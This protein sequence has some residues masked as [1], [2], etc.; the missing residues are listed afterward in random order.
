VKV[1]LLADP[2]QAK[3]LETFDRLDLLKVGFAPSA[4]IVP[5]VTC[6]LLISLL[7]R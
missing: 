2:L 3:P 1:I 4:R 6:K 7:L 5:V